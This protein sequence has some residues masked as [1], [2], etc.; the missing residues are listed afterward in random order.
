MAKR[1]RS[2]ASS[3]AS[4]WAPGS[5]TDAGGHIAARPI[6]SC[7]RHTNR[8]AC[9][10]V[11]FSPDIHPLSRVYTTPPFFGGQLSTVS[12]ACAL[13]GGSHVMLRS[14]Y[15]KSDKGAYKDVLCG[16]QSVLR[17]TASSIEPGASQDTLL[18]HLQ[19]LGRL[20]VIILAA[21]ASAGSPPQRT[22]QPEPR[23]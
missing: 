18:P 4:R 11:G 8:F 17:S 9:S 10:H 14:K 22:S 23:P 6:S 20:R 19:L 13:P 5:P 2:A 12:I 3:S 21:V 16:Q 7:D 1:G 15:L